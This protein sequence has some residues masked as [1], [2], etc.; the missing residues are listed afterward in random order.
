MV[1]VFTLRW[2]ALVASRM[3]SASSIGGAKPD[4]E[5]NASPAS[6]WLESLR[7]FI[8]SVMTWRRRAGSSMS[9][10]S[11]ANMADTLFSYVPSPTALPDG[12][13][14]TDRDGHQCAHDPLDV[15]VP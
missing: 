4:M 8:C 11:S 14:R 2:P 13:A 12:V 6:A 9:T 5:V 1:T 15:L 7:S 10:G 3:P